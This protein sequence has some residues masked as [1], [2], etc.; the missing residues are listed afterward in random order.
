MNGEVDALAIS[1]GS[2]MEYA[3]GG[4]AKVIAAIGHERS[5]LAPKVGLLHE[6]VQLAPGPK[7]WMD[8]RLGIKA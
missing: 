4:R 2:G 5:E 6:M 1:E 3:Q 8:F 7:W